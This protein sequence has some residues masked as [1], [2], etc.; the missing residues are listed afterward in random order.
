MLATAAIPSRAATNRFTTSAAQ[1][2]SEERVGL[3][4]ATDRVDERRTASS[5]ESRAGLSAR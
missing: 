2:A 3:D 1:A 5:A 4:V